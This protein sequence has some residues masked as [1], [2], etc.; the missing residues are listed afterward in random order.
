RP[1]RQGAAA[2]ASRLAL[3]ISRRRAARLRLN[4]G[5]PMV[6]VSRRRQSRERTL[7][8]APLVVAPRDEHR[9]GRGPPTPEEPHEPPIHRSEHGT[10]ADGDTRPDTRG[11]RVTDRPRRRRR[12][13]RL[14]RRL[15][16]PEHPRSRY[17]PHRHL[18]PLPQHA[19]G[20]QRERL[21]R[22][23]WDARPL[24]ARPAARL[25]GTG[26]AMTPPLLAWALPPLGGSSDLPQSPGC[27]YP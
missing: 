11:G 8:S 1:H 14:L 15:W 16:R 2:Q 23:R 10:R 27:L 18:Q 13:P 5:N 24:R 25:T 17:R 19:G 3:D 12:G 26:L 21:R 6:A 7:R 9:I 20:G 4:V 22:H